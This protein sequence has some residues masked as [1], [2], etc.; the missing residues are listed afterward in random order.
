MAQR[1]YGFIR[2]GTLV[3]K[4]RNASR[5]RGCKNNA[6]QPTKPASLPAPASNWF[7]LPGRLGPFRL[8]DEA[9]PMPQLCLRRAPETPAT[10]EEGGH[11]YL[12]VG[13]RREIVEAAQRVAWRTSLAACS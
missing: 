5:I 6:V 4:V 13:E 2:V 11:R 1:H 12:T 8:T 9:E 3:F 10:P 7:D